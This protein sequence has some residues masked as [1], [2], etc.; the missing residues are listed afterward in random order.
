MLVELPSDLSSSALYLDWVR[1]HAPA[2]E[3]DA[4][5]LL[6][7]IRREIGRARAKPGRFLDDM[8]RRARGLP[9]EHLP[10]FWDTV[11]HRLSRVAPRHAATAYGVAREA[12]NTHGLP[13][14]PEY[15]TANALLYARA[16]AL[17]GKEMRAHQ[18]WLASAF[19]AQRAH[20]EFLRFVRA[21]SEGGAPPA[22]DLHTR[23]RA[24]AKAAGL[25]DEDAARVLGEVLAAAKGV[26][27]PNGLLDGA[28]KLLAK[29]PPADEVRQA[30]ADMFPPT[31]TDGAAFLRLLR[32]AGVI[33]AMADGRVTPD[34]GLA[35]WL[36]RYTYL[37]SYRRES[38][39]GV[40][41]HP[42]PDE[43]Y[44]VLPL[45]APRLRAAG[46]PVH[47]HEGRY[48]WT[49]FDADLVDACLAEGIPVHDPGPDVRLDYWG[50]RSRR[51]LKALA[52]HPVLGKRL[53]GTVHARH[54]RESPR[55]GGTAITRLV[56]TPQ[57]ADSVRERITGLIDQVA[58]GG[59]GT[60]DEAVAALDGLLDTPTAAA[61]DGID[62]ALAALDLT[63]PLLRTLRTGL[64][65]ELGWPALDEA[66]AE[67]TEGGA[68]I[69][70]VTSTWPVLT[71]FTADRAIAVDHN[72]RRAECAFTVPG[73][74]A[75]RVVFYAGG[76][77]L[78]GWGKGSEHADR[79][80][81][82]SDP[83]TVFTPDDPHGMAPLSQ[84]YR[85]T[86]GYQLETA[87][88]GGRHDGRRVLRP[89]DRCAPHW[90]AGELLGDG[91]GLWTAS[92]ND[93][94]PAAWHRI[95]PATGE[96]TETH[97]LPAFFADPLPD[98]TVLDY[99][100]LSLIRLPDGVTGSPL[101]QNAHGLAGFRVT[102]TRDERYYTL[103]GVDG[104][105]AVLSRT[106]RGY[107]WGV[108]RMPDGPDL[109]V[110]CSNGSDMHMYCYDA[111]DGSLLWRVRG[112]T[113]RA[114]RH[115]RTVFPP[116]A[117]WHFLRPRD[118]QSSRALRQVDRDAAR[119]LLDAARDGDA[120]VRAAL[121][122]V[123]PEVADPRVADGVA[124]VA[125][126]AARVLARREELSRRVAVVRSGA[127]VRPPAETPDA[128]LLPALRGLILGKVPHDP[129][130]QPALVTAVAAD[131]AYLAGRADEQVRW[132]SRPAPA[133]DWTVLLGRIDAAA[134]RLLA[135]P[136]SDRDRAALAALLRT[137]AEQPFA[138]SGR[139]RIGRAAGAQLR[140]LC[141][142]GR[143]VVPG[144]AADALDPDRSY[145]FVQ[146]ADTPPPAGAED[147][148]TVAV[149]RDDASRLRRVLD[150]LDERGPLPL[151]EAAVEAFARRTGVRRSMAALALAGLPR[152]A[153]F[154]GDLLS[155]CQE[156]EKMLRA[157]PYQATKQGVREAE[158]LSRELGVD[159]RLRVLAAAMPD[160]PA[161]LWA[162]GGP[163]AAA[164]RMAAEWARLLGTRQRVDEATAVQLEKDLGLGDRWAAALADP[165]GSDVAAADPRYV[166]AV[167]D[168]G[169]IEAH[170][171]D[172]DG[173]ISYRTRREGA[174]YTTLAAVLIWALTQRPV[175]DPAL[176]GVPE[177]H[178]RLRARLDSP[179]L[180]LPLGLVSLR[181]S[182]EEKRELF[183][184]R[185]IPVRPA[186]NAKKDRARGPLAYDDGL[187]IIDGHEN[188]Q[189][190]HLRPAGFAD[191]A[192]MERVT[193]LCAEHDLPGLL[194]QVRQYKVMYDDGL[195]RMVA[196]AADTPVPPGGYEANPLLSV[197]D[198]VDEV[199]E[200]LRASRD[201]AAL[202][203]QLLTLARP[204]DR[205][206]RTWNGWTA[207]RHKAAEAEL[208]ERGAVVQEKRPRAGR[209]A[210]IPG[211]WTE[212]KAPHLPL[213]TYKL[214]LHLAAADHRRKE[215]D[216]PVT[217]LMP[218]KPLHEMF[219]DA[220]H[221]R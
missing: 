160:D 112:F 119:A 127:L 54:V 82:A 183:G 134:W 13:I 125:Q 77:F 51:D 182:A 177:L 140:P 144:S 192:A 156:H 205:N 18:Q 5:T 149:A 196:R 218:P 34:G 71:V 106:H 152:K 145:R 6:D 143:A 23:L 69:E 210:F 150:L 17:A 161:E 131:G 63:G 121:A 169:R 124:A 188:L 194:R 113:G 170:E 47:L 114:P 219:A 36:G 138:R 128:H 110:T 98:G 159:G 22:A 52:A 179:D 187:L 35:R 211:D 175:G 118:P 155:R 88:G 204:T 67:L 90:D 217:R 173:R 65:D 56:G 91:T 212:L 19:P 20:E 174:P 117:F 104:R 193:R 148:E 27:V 166:L 57:I 4:Q 89:G 2:W 25:G 96:A 73:D 75:V 3:K 200:A 86:L 139:W 29:H 14:D 132:L 189:W 158:E 97:S 130:R 176:A 207:A 30:L 180:F 126:W 209:T 146:P 185:T 142:S 45:L 191:P 122:R 8:Q 154:D 99:E 109:V 195:A 74:A 95:D 42:L 83:G 157:K 28:A 221:G 7:A 101:G 38:L 48:R 80:Y 133:E 49:N 15:R 147:V 214:D 84:R 53:E 55:A 186:E 167:S 1:A 199:A 26:E 31:N 216:A 116:P 79:A 87:D 58:G 11:G 123:L 40:M 172:E 164:E 115:G 24:S 178:D 102:R 153:D 203:L 135:A 12:E 64:P 141:E 111:E 85:L 93:Y 72:G 76:D 59:L 197:P 81:W 37:Y 50:D 198:L 137:W 220:W 60:A 43:L 163:V 108:I 171:L 168:Y 129:T 44:E 120:A 39:G 68:D 184:P 201:A 66:L 151:D 206:V 92:G 41:Q 105:R 21:W 70:G 202:Y 162:D 208:V 103:E 10:W 100:N 181:M 46:K 16:G 165:A 61:L 62:E 213:E 32:A 33:D 78:I 9:A 94:Q 107:P 215:V 136:T 190:P